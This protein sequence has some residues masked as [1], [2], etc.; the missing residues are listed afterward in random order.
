MRGTAIPLAI[1]L[2]GAMAGCTQQSG[3]DSA[4]HYENKQ[5]GKQGGG[6]G[7][8]GQSGGSQGQGEAQ[9]NADGTA[10]QNNNGAAPNLANSSNVDDRQS[11]PTPPGMANNDSKQQNDQKKNQQSGSGSNANPPH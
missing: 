4:K 11:M 3:G 8:P 7:Q 10:G 2:C 5:A 1:G 9:R 6:A